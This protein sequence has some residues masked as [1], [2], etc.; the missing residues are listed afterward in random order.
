[1]HV[2]VCVSVSKRELTLGLCVKNPSGLKDGRADPAD[3]RVKGL[4]VK[5]EAGRGRFPVGSSP[6]CDSV[7]IVETLRGGGR[8]HTFTLT[9]VWTILQ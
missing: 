7:P 2:C 5:V 6:G 8:G 1:M 3:C 9:S 4:S